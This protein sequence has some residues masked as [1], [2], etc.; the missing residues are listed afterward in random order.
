MTPAVEVID[1]VKHYPQ[2]TGYRDVVRR[3]RSAPGGVEPRPA[4][5]GISLEIAPG[6]LF[7]LLGQNGGQDHP[8][9]DHHGPAHERTAR[10]PG[11]DVENDTM[12]VR[13]SIGL[14]PARSAR[15]TGA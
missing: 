6:E 3:S 5:A 4:L 7:G 15:S 13:R 10:G 9:P 1:L 11:P 14:T 12:G 2:A 8:D